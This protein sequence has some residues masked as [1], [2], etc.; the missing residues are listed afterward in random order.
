ML[1]R[2]GRYPW[3][4]GED[5]YQRLDRLNASYKKYHAEGMSDSDIAKKL[6]M[7]LEDFQAARLDK[8]Y[9]DYR[10]LRK[11]GISD[12]DIAKK[13]GMSIIE[14]RAARS[15][16]K[17]R[18]ANQQRIQV[19]KL[20]E[21]GY[22]NV[23]I[24]EKLGISEGTVRNYRNEL[25]GEK[26]SKNRATAD[27]LKKNA[28]KY[29]Y[30]DVSV[31]TELQLSGVS[32]DRL[33]TALEILKDEGY[34]VENIYVPQATMPGQYTTVKVLAKP[35]TKK[36]DIYQNMDKIHIINETTH[37]NGKSWDS[38]KEPESFSSKRL[39]V[40]Y[41]DQGGAAKDGVIELRRGVPDISLGGSNYAQVR[42]KVDD[43]LYLKGMAMYADDLPPGIDIRFNSSKKSGT[44]LKDTLKELKK[45]PGTNEID[46]ENPFGALIKAGGQVYYPDPKGK[47]I[48]PETGERC[49]ISVVNKLREEGDWDLYS[50]TLS[51][52]FLSKQ[53]KE[54]VKKQLDI[55]WQDKL[56]EYKEIEA[57]DNPVI[58]R[59]FLEQFAN[60]CDASAVELKAAALPRQSSK[61][62]LPMDCMKDN[63]VYAPSYKD[64]EQLALIRYPHEGI[65]QIP[66]LTVNNHNPKAKKILPASS[67]DA[68]GI[69]S[70]VAKIMSGADFDGDTVMC[71]P[72]H[73]GYTKVNNLKPL[74]GLKDFDPSEAFPGYPG[75]HVMDNGATSGPE[76]AIEMGKISNLITDMTLKGAPPEDLTRAVRHSM[77]VIDSPKHK[78]D[79][80]ASEQANGIA[81]LKKKW[82]GSSNAGASTLVSRAS[83]PLDIPERK[84]GQYFNATTGKY[85][86]GN[87]RE[88]ID[89]LKAKGN[90][91]RIR[92]IDPE[93][94]KKLYR[95][96]GGTHNKPLFNEV[97][98]D[99][100]KVK[101]Y[102]R[103]ENGR[104]VYDKSK[105]IPNVQKSTKMAEVDDAFK[106]STGHIIETFYATYANNLKHLANESRKEMVRLS[107][108]SVDTN[109][110]IK[111]ANEVA[112][113][114]AKLDTALMNA[115]KERKAQLVAAK[116]MNELRK[117][118][119]EL[120][121]KYDKDAQDKLK[122]YAQR[123][124]SD[125]RDIYGA[126]KKEVSIDISEKEWEA[127]KA[128]AVSSSTLISIINNTDTDKLRKLATPT[129]NRQINQVKVSRA[130]A[131][132]AN[133]Y[134]LEEI[135]DK[136]G[137][138]PSTVANYIK[139]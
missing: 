139:M 134:T 71:I 117:V 122:K 59:H 58:R 61:V 115:P 104:K 133:G 107:G 21:H 57:I 101:Y 23:K 121:N 112:S 8:F 14:F 136:L 6:N 46:K 20:A 9:S 36:N 85:I 99:G 131:L 100:K 49:S 91:I 18:E 86:E 29:G 48:N 83:G 11:G 55:S 68:I 87:D 81:A 10:D 17:E 40:V 12:N 65:F 15:E 26:A 56:Q 88:L 47:Y 7:S 90:D 103:D 125:A 135:A 19:R 84:E 128:N 111:Y 138:S 64:G 106:L 34:V 39:Q 69:N 92:Y 80:K 42:I 35:D 53:P 76:K 45:V 67:V 119:N 24:A 66:I 16:A 33:K 120:N 124:L 96:T 1:E 25:S 3:G 22:S 114:K 13:Y 126:H 123:A 43:D 74:E 51:S 30:V 97:E 137:V 44:P 110:K 82:Q 132:S 98:E 60:D 72:T 109:A 75:M 50:R 129:N 93:T 38:F 79:Y 32:K 5:P 73:N 27:I 37:D 130:K 108:Y 77:V 105:D 62:I 28:D 4:S 41:A 54:M 2:S 70:S 63:E 52:Q 95:N 116:K 102:I 89:K 78:L 94:G 31:G 113:L 127:I 118:H